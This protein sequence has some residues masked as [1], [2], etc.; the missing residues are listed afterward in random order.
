MRLDQHD[1]DT[2]AD[3]V[4]QR[5]L[6]RLLAELRGQQPAEQPTNGHLMNAR[7]LADILGISETT[8]RTRERDGSI[9]SLRTG[10]RVLFDVAAV[11]ES[12][13][14]PDQATD[15]KCETTPL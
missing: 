1:I 15:E 5:I 6:P 10:S 14:R 7:Q 3:A 9:P 8:L 13:R 2:L 11:I 12:M 4:A